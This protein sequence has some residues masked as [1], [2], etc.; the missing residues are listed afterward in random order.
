M[1]LGRYYLLYTDFPCPEEIADEVE[2]H[3]DVLAPGRAQRVLKQRLSSLV[4]LKNCNACPTR[5]GCNERQ[6][7]TN[8]QSFLD[9][10]PSRNVLC[11]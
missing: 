9:S 7:G 8:K 5:L 10:V 11:L 1:L 2:T 4:F 3:V 6:N